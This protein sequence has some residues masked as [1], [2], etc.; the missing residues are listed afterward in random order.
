MR[1]ASVGKTP[2]AS[3]DEPRLAPPRRGG[4]SQAAAVGQGGAAQRRRRR[5]RRRKPPNAVRS[6][7]AATGLGA[8]PPNEQPPEE[9]PPSPEGVD[10]EPPLPALPLPPEPLMVSRHKA[11]SKWQRQMHVLYELYR[12]VLLRRTALRALF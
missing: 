11:P 2:S 8:P 6:P 9:P 7:S 3:A 5:A 10:P 4:A 1:I 12:F